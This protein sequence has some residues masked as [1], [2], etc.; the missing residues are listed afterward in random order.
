[1][2]EPCVQLVPNRSSPLPSKPEMRFRAGDL[3]RLQVV[4]DPIEAQDQI[5]RLLRDRRRGQ[6]L[7]KIAP[8]VRVAGR[9]LAPRHLRDDVAAAVR[10][11]DQR[12]LGATEDP[13]G[14]LTIP[15]AG[16]KLEVARHRR[17][18]EPHQ[19]IAD[20]RHFEGIY[21]ESDQSESFARSP[22]GRGLEAYADAIGGPS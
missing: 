5:D 18:R 13:L 7:V 6:R 9:A 21:R 8:Q 19:R 16:G 15:I 20:P 1:M 11:D 12:A 22:I 4:L 2:E 10:I 14:R 3:L 17:G